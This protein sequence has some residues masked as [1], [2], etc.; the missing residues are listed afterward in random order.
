MASLMEFKCPSCG[1]AVAFDSETQKMKCTY[2]STLYDQAILEQYDDALK[3]M[4]QEDNYSWNIDTSSDW[5]EAEKEQLQVYVCQSCGGEIVGEPTTVAT[6]CPYCDNP[7]VF[8][9]QVSGDLKPDYLIPFRFNKQQAEEA[10]RKHIKGKRFAPREFSTNAHIEKIKGVY[11]PF[12]VFDSTA[13]ANLRYKATK[14]RHWSDRNY[15]YTENSV[16]SVLRTGRINYNK[17]P[18]DASSKIPDDL[19]QSIEPFDTS[20]AVPF[21]AGYLSGYMA[22]RYDEDEK[23]CISKA[24]QRIEQS[25]LE[26]FQATLQGYSSIN[27]ESKSI[28]LSDSIAK[29]MLYPVW[30]LN[31]KYQDKDYIFAMNGQTG[32]FVGDLPEDR[33]RSNLWLFLLALAFAL[34][35]YGIA[36][37]IHFL[38]G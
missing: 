14:V 22:D 5:S 25:T 17:V 31:S 4:P 20:T 18:V 3:N 30:I 10:F 26:A 7:V 27:L 2:C 34:G 37:I 11:L 21:N 35:I 19:M 6:H 28:V 24:N 32:R 15:K 16:F 23:S 1:G 38:I 9:G 8:A 29:Y 12:W 33:K 36:S 13:N